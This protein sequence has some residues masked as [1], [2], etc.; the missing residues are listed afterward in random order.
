M[1]AEPVH[2]RLSGRER[3]R[4]ALWTR[5]RASARA[6]TWAISARSAVA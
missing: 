5:R 1:A 6:S 3:P 2:G 4:E